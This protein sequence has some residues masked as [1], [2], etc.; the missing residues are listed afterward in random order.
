MVVLLGEKREGFCGRP[1]WR[2]E[3]RLLWSS[4]LAK[5]GKAS[6]VVL[7]GEKEK[8]GRL[9]WSSCLAKI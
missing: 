9:L 8:E 2:K 7:L 1:A 5:R 3:G 6:V 4:C